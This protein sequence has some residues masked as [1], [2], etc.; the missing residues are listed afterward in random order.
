M[1]KT[2]LLGLVALFL[3]T[4]GQS[5]ADTLVLRDGTRISGK[6]ISKTKTRITFRDEKGVTKRY[7]PKQ[8]EALDIESTGQY[9]LY[10]TATATKAAAKQG[11]VTSKVKSLEVV[12]SGTELVIRT[13]EAINSK[14]ATANQTF[15]AQFD[16]DVLGASGK[17]V[18]PKGS[19]AALVIRTASSG[20]VTGS[21]EMTLDIQSITV[22]GTS[23]IV[24]TADLAQKGDTGL[25]ANKRTAEMVGGGTAVGAIIGAIAGK[26]KGA[27]IGAVAGAAAGAG[28]QILVKGK[29]VQVPAETVL[30]FQLDQ[31]VSLQAV[32]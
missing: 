17:V 13:N 19:P 29:E 21:P 16:E 11:A 27:V 28:T 26:G 2:F 4:T 23:Y 20:G 30:R 5:W 8:L 24:S 18:I 15:S 12:P 14:T 25:G 31:A 3:L 6:L 9:I 7:T 32:K 22:A 1:K 10:N